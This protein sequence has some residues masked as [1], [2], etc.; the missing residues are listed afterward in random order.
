MQFTNVKMACQNTYSEQ[1][2]WKHCFPV[3]LVAVG[4]GVIC[5]FALSIAGDWCTVLHSQQGLPSSCIQ[6]KTILKLILIHFQNPLVPWY[7]WRLAL[8]ARWFFCC[9][10]LFWLVESLV[11]L[12]YCF[13]TSRHSKPATSKITDGTNAVEPIS[14]CFVSNPPNPC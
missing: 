13:V 5:A 11:L 9:F 3:L 10:V 14:L 12:F 1:D 7:S 4:S 2:R 6:M 8:T